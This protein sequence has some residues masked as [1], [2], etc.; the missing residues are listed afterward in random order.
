[1]PHPLEHEYDLTA[2]EL[3]DAINRRFRAKVTLEG[4]VAEVHLGKKLKALR[5]RGGLYHFEEHDSDGYPDY[6]IWLPGDDPGQLI[7]CKIYGMQMKR[8]EKAVLMS[9]TRLRPKRLAPRITI[10]APVF[11]I[12]TISPFSP[13]VWVKRRID[14]LTLCS[15]ALGTLRDTPSILTSLLSCT[16]CHCRIPILVLRGIVL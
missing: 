16:G 5:D 10:Q 14:G 15:S 11:T 12:T 3:L 9:P 2:T 6:T 13:F 4:A 7:E 1:M 8:T